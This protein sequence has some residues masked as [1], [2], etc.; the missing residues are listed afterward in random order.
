[1]VPTTFEFSGISCEITDPAE[2]KELSPI[3]T[4]G[5]MIAPEPI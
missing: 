5:S 1:M 4:P 2:I 3:L